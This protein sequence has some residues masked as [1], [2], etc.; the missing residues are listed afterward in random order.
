MLRPDGVRTGEGACERPCPGSDCVALVQRGGVCICPGCG[1]KDGAPYA[2]VHAADGLDTA[3]VRA[4]TR[5][6]EDLPA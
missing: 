6:V 1:W 4:H 5:T 3:R 2:A